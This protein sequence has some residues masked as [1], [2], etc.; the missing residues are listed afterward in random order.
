[1]PTF[2]FFSGQVL[3]LS[4]WKFT[5]LDLSFPVLAPQPGI[6]YVHELI[7]SGDLQRQPLCLG[8]SHTAVMGD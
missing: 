5:L 1:M 7:T 4:F 3:A 6:P 2:F 8:S